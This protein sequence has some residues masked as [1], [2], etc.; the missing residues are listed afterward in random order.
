MHGDR[1]LLPDVSTRII[2]T[3]PALFH[4]KNISTVRVSALAFIACGTDIPNTGALDIENVQDF[5]LIDCSLEDSL[6]ASALAAFNVDMTILRTSFINNSAT[7][8]GGGLSAYSSNVYLKDSEFVM[9]HAYYGGAV[10]AKKSNISVNGTNILYNYA[11]GIG[12]GLYF[13]SSFV[14]F[15][16]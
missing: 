1:A 4:S 6:Y 3:E 12:G 16:W 7:N 15:Q 11:D 13:S 8:V 5:R 2:C 14:V 9:N 10:Y